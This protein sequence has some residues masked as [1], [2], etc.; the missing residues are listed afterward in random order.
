MCKCVRPG[1]ESAA[2]CLSISFTLKNSEA[3]SGAVN[4]TREANNERGGALGQPGDDSLG[5]PRSRNP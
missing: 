3:H 1:E 2:R 4:Q 5:P